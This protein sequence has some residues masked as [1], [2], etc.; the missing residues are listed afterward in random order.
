MNRNRTLRLLL[1]LVSSISFSLTV[2]RANPPITN[3][4]SGSASSTSANKAQADVSECA[5]EPFTYDNGPLGQ[6]HWC[7]ACNLD[8]SKLQAPININTKAARPD[9]SLPSINFSGWSTDVSYQTPT[10]GVIPTEV[11]R[12]FGPGAVMGW[13]FSPTAGGL[14]AI[15]PGLTSA[16]LVVQTNAPSYDLTAFATVS[17][18]G[19]GGDPLGV[20][21]S[22]GSDAWFVR[23]PD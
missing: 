6:S 21:S 19:F 22:P 5:K 13:N 4:Q 16:T 2:C 15:A 10:A 1:A 11:D 7:G 14:G 8:T 20:R 12:S 3:A 17:L 18:F 9:G 23:R